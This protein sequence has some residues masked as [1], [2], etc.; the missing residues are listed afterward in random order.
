VEEAVGLPLDIKRDDDDGDDDGNIYI[1]TSWS[2]FYVFR[3]VSTT[4]LF[5]GLNH[6]S[7]R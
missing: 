6:K 1:Y 2:I 4:Q 5:N 7:R 3:T